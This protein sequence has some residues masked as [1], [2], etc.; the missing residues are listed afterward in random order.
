MIT[1]TTRTTTFLTTEF[2]EFEIPF[3]QPECSENSPI[4]RK[5]DTGFI[6]GII[7][8]DYYGPDIFKDWNGNGEILSFHR[9]AG[10]EMHQRAYSAMGTY[11]DNGEPATPYH[12]V[13]SCYQHGCEVWSLKGQGEQ[14]HFDTAQVAGVWIP[15]K[16]AIENIDAITERDGKDKNEVID[17]YVK[18]ILDTY[19]KVLAGEVYGICF[20]HYDL[21][22]NLVNQDACWQYVGWKDTVEEMKSQLG[23]LCANKK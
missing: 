15:D 13:L 10:A 8:H 17:T 9:H 6:I 14:C 22:R 1:S 11:A 7:Y 4:I 20:A 2:G 19:N 18:R 16:C 12:R 3:M 21:D 23:V 5:T